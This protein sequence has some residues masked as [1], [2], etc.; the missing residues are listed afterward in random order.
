VSWA[1]YDG[2]RRPDRVFI[3]GGAGSGKTTVGRALAQRW[4][5]SHYEMDLGQH[6]D[7]VT[8]SR[9][10]VEGG[11]L[12]D[13][14][15]YLEIADLVVWLDLS[16]VVTIP[17]IVTRHVTLSLRRQNRHRGLRLLARFVRSQASYNRDPAHRPTEPLDYSQTRAGTEEILEPYWD[18]VV[19]LRTPRDVRRWLRAGDVAHA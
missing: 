11:G 7:A 15:R 2:L 4:S 1:Q 19:H 13:V 3:T 16:P 5:L 6:D 9:W 10:V 17:R 18:R 14:E 12:W 8:Q